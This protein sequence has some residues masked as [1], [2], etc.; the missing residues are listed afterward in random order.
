[1]REISNGGGFERGL[2]VGC[3]NAA[4]ELRLLQDGLVGSFDLFEIT[5]NRVAKGKTA[6][7]QYGVESRAHFRVEDAFSQEL[8]N[9]YDLVYWNNALHHMFDVTA[10][11]EWSRERLRPGGFLVMDDFVGATRFQWPDVQLQIATK[12]RRSLPKRLLRSPTHPEQ[13]INPVVRRPSVEEMLA[14]DPSEA[15]DSENILPAL[16]KVFPQAEIVLT[17]GVIYH[18][19]LNDVITNFE[20]TQ[21]AE[22]LQTLLDFDADLASHGQTHYASA[23]ACKN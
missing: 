7:K 4:K 23:F 22:L 12:I 16:R 17:G 20:D 14:S 18:L 8:A 9:Q 2:S 15:A 3:G 11:L 19:T 21:D 6:A 5:E 10:A 1:M 13:W